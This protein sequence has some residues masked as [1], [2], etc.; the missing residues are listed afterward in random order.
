MQLTLEPAVVILK[1]FGC[2]ICVVKFDLEDICTFVDP[3][4]INNTKFVAHVADELVLELTCASII[5]SFVI[6]SCGCGVTGFSAFQ[7]VCCSCAR[8]LI[9]FVI[10]IIGNISEFATKGLVFLTE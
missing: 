6:R 1:P 3:K 2:I 5:L 7:P 8:V 4:R 9:V 10:V